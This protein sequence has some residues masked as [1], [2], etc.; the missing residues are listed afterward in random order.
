M[1]RRALAVRMDVTRLDQIQGAT[2]EAVAAMG[3][4]DCLV[5]NAGLGPENPAE[6]VTEEDFDLTCDVNLKGT[7]F[8]QPGGRPRPPCAGVGHDR[9]LELAG[10]L[11]GAPDR[12]G[13][14]Q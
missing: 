7:F 9:Q 4:I 12:V 13:L 14:L 11:R 6:D 2:D 8:R 10:W 5:N 3:R 1:G